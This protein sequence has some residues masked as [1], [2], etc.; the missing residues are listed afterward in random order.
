MKAIIILI[1]LAIVLL[2][3]HLI[4]NVVKEKEFNYFLIASLG[5]LLTISLIVLTFFIF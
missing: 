4:I 1:L 3:V 2:Y 5:L